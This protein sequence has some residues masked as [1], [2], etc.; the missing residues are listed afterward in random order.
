MGFAMESHKNAIFGLIFTVK[1]RTHGTD[2]GMDDTITIFILAMRKCPIF[3]V[4]Y[5]KVKVIRDVLRHIYI[6]FVLVCRSS[7]WDP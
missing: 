4:K 6:I 3:F 5:K 7:G 1:G 2:F